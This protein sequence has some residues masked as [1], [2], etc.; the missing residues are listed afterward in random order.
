[1]AQREAELGEA[2][3]IEEP[4][5]PRLPAQRG[6]AAHREPDSSYSKHYEMLDNEA[7]VQPE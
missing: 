5:D 1:M 7:P 6:R 3:G 2:L 4:V